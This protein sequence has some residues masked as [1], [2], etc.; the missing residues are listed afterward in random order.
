MV[1]T[2]VNTFQG[3]LNNNVGTMVFQGNG[4]RMNNSAY[5]NQGTLVLDNTATNS[6]IAS[7]R[8]A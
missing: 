4:R 8:R 1:L 6:T 2:N 7:A 3:A 5:V